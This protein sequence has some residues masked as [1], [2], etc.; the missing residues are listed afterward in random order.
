M[1]NTIEEMSPEGLELDEATVRQQ[2]SDLLT[3]DGRPLSQIAIE[4]GVAYATLSAWRAGTYKGRNDRIAAQV[5]SWMVTREARKRTRV[6]VPREPKFQQTPTASAMLDVLEAAHT[7]P[8]MAV[9]AGSAGIGK[10][11][12]AKWYQRRAANV[13]L[14]TMEPSY[15]TMGSVL[16][17]IAEAVG[18][19]PTNS[20][21]RTS[22]LIR[23]RLVG[24]GGLLIVDE[25][26]NLS[27][28]AIDQI[29]TF[30]DRAEIGI[31]LVGNETVA[32]RFGRDRLSMEYA[33]LF[34]RIGQKFRQ[35]SLTAKDLTIL[36][37]A[38][39]L[40]DDGARG[41]ARKV[42]KMPGAARLMGKVLKLA[43]LRANNDG[44][45]KPVQADVEAAWDQ[46]GNRVEGGA[47]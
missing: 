17:A 6:A 5:H 40:E 15:S 16:S 24:T 39:E 22:D 10:T 25:A 3:A 47:A 23:R 14:V 13:W 8:D 32:A 12:T 38:W 37:D 31:A 21:A 30:H 19:S 18:I 41:V 45:D 4:A 33:P 7:L 36:I 9:I 44:R 27:A 20:T 2:F 26:Q 28:A 34:S 29:R 11:T 35:K 46:L 43:F 1:G 42:G